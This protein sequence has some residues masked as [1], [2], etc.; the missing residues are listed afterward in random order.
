MLGVNQWYD[1]YHWCPI[2]LNVAKALTTSSSTEYNNEN[3]GIAIIIKIIAG[4]IVQ[5]ISNNEA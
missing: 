3:E 5:I 1:Q 4:I 2:A